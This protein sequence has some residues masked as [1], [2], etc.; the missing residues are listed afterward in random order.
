MIPFL[1]PLLCSSIRW[2]RRPQ[3]SLFQR[4]HRR[5]RSLV[6]RTL[7]TTTASNTEPAFAFARFERLHMILIARTERRPAPPLRRRR[8]AESDGLCR[9]THVR[10]TAERSTERALAVPECHR[11]CAQFGDALRCGCA[12]AQEVRA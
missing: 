9:R 8:N 2:R 1:A 5:T 7:P 12:E 10:V 11:A 6:Q 4:C 3:K